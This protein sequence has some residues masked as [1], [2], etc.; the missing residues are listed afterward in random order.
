MT[1]EAI[2]QVLVTSGDCGWAKKTAV[3]HVCSLAGNTRP[4]MTP[5]RHRNKEETH[6]EEETHREG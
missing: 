6:Q 4:R 3:L 2:V 1:T 5:L